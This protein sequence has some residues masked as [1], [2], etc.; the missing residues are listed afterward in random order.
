VFSQQVSKSIHL[1]IGAALQLNKGEKTCYR[2]NQPGHFARECPTQRQNTLV[3]A[4]QGND[5]RAP[6]RG[7]APLK[8]TADNTLAP[9]GDCAGFQKRAQRAWECGLLHPGPLTASAEPG[10]PEGPG[11]SLGPYP[12]DARSPRPRPQGSHR[13]GLK[14]KAGP[15]GLLRPKV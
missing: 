14:A 15:S 13:L 8:T 9:T 4:V 7:P 10:E 12:V 6:L 2:C 11:S 5:Q 1:A 3:T